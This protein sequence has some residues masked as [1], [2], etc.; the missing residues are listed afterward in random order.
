VARAVL[1]DHGC[2]FAPSAPLFGPAEQR[3]GVAAIALEVILDTRQRS[4]GP[5]R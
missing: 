1:A 4:L 2:F 5:R 3:H